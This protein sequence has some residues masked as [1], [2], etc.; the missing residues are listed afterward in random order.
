VKI[1][2]MLRKSTNQSILSQIARV[3][4][5]NDR[6]LKSNQNWYRSHLSDYY[7]KSYSW[8]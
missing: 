2:K 8:L 4:A 5:Q 7:F 1:A 3:I 6:L